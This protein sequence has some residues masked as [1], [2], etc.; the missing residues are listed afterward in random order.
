MKTNNLTFLL[1]QVVKIKEKDF[2]QIIPLAKD[3][4]AVIY[5]KPYKEHQLQLSF[6]NIST[7]ELLLF[8]GRTTPIQGLYSENLSDLFMEISS[9]LKALEKNHA[10]YQLYKLKPKSELNKISKSKDFWYYNLPKNT[11]LELRAVDVY[12]NDLMD[13]TGVYK[14]DVDKYLISAEGNAIHKD[15]VIRI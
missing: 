5:P 6:V 3:I 14:G 12:S 9:F 13:T 7:W 1:S 10:K 4:Y 8:P 2:S 15:A 11:V